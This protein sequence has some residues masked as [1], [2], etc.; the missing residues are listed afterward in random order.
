MSTAWYIDFVGIYAHFIVQHPC[1]VFLWT[2]LPEP[3]QIVGV[4][5]CNSTSQC[6]Q[7]IPIVDGLSAFH[8]YVLGQVI[9]VSY[10]LSR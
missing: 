7:N 9:R 1:D 4:V 8:I 10:R 3:E 5:G 6:T 2:Y